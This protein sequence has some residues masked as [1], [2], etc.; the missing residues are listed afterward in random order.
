[1]SHLIAYDIVIGLEV[2][3]V[4]HLVALKRTKPAAERYSLFVLHK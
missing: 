3:N 2:R 1:M 4:A